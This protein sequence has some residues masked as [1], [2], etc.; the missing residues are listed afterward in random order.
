MISLTSR[1]DA[2]DGIH[3]AIETQR[4]GAGLDVQSDDSPDEACRD[5]EGAI[6]DDD[7][8][9]TDDDVVTEYSDTQD[10]NKGN[11][12]E[13]SPPVRQRRTSIAEDVIG[14]KGRYGRFVERWLSRKGWSVEGRR[15]QGMSVEEASDDA[16]SV[17]DVNK[18]EV[19]SPRQADGDERLPA[20]EG[21][22]PRQSSSIS[23]DLSIKLLRTIHTLFASRSYF[24]SYD[25]D[26][27]RRIGSG[28]PTTDGTAL[29]EVVDPL[30]G[31]SL[32]G[33]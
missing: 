8:E 31:V 1:N 32:A 27:T 7:D 6:G 11:L 5:D 2:E 23:P 14:K 24:F 12:A 28:L 16:D 13:A 21:E 33:L 30:V 19:V 25:H 22:S 29:H 10:D 15:M 20:Q 26:I 18:P 3:K 9:E 17:P 4:K